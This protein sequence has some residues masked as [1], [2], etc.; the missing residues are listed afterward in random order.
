[1][2]DAEHVGILCT[3]CG[4]PLG[5]RFLCVRCTVKLAKSLRDVPLLVGALD[6][7]MAM[8]TKR[9]PWIGDFTTSGGGEQPLRVDLKASALA[10]E[11]HQRLAWTVRELCEE[12]G[13]EYGG[14]YASIPLA[15]WLAH[16]ADSIALSDHAVDTYK[17]LKR[18]LG[19]CWRHVDRPEDLIFLGPCNTNECLADVYAKAGDAVGVCEGCKSAHD[20]AYRR[21]WLWSQT[22]D[23]LASIDVIVLASPTI[24]GEKVTPARFKVWRARDKIIGVPCAD[25]QTRYRLGDVT[26][27]LLAARLH[28]AEK[29]KRTA[30]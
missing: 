20:V 4:E 28:E 21:R 19:Q 10:D 3:P 30:A 5:D 22:E 7:S 25:G 14:V 12:R 1:M 15:L 8:L 2:T 24:Y 29:K 6:D 23:S 11:L 27:L 17:D 18:I 16:S 9:G 26:A 13:R